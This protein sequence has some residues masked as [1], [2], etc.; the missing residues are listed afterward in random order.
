MIVV[1][2]VLF[3]RP[4]TSSTVAET[5]KDPKNP[6]VDAPWV[7]AS[8]YMT[9]VAASLAHLYTVGV[10][11]TG[12][13]GP[14]VTISRLFSPSPRNVFSALPGSYEALKEGVHL[15][16]QYDLM[17]TGAACLVFVHCMLQ[18]IPKKNGKPTWVGPEIAN[19]EL[20]YLAI[21]SAVLG[22]AGAGSFGLAVREKRLRAELEGK[23]K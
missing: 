21:S 14:E 3:S 22:P 9:A 12:A 7:V 10:A 15:F 13:A 23:N 8:Y 19:K 20:L 2:V 17:I 5:P 11:L 1:A 18:S 6:N 16:T 4:G